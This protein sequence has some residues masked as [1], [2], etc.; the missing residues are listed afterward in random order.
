MDKTEYLEDLKVGDRLWYTQYS[1]GEGHNGLL[2]CEAEVTTAREYKAIHT[3]DD[4]EII[5]K[6]VNGERIRDDRATFYQNMPAYER[7]RFPKKKVMCVSG[8]WCPAT[9]SIN[10]SYI[11]L[12]RELL[13][14][15]I[16]ERLAAYA[17]SMKDTANRCIANLNWTLDNTPI[18]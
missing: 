2:V 3:A 13:T 15:T 5:F 7:E 11:A 14:E 8:N 4:W 16:N 6:A 1:V 12:T 18:Q 10:G 9:D 17:N